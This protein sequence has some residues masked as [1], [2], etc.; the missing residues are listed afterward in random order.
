MC[1]H[2][3]APSYDRLQQ[4]FGVTPVEPAQVDIWPGYQGPFLRSESGEV[5]AC[6][7]VFGLLPGWAKDQ[8][9]ARRTYNARSETVSEKPSYRSAWRQAR[10][11]VIPAV[12]IYEPDWRTGKAVPARIARADGGLMLIAGLWDCWS[13]PDCEQ[14]FSYT[15]LT[16][17]ADD[18]PLM[19][20]YHRPEDEKR[21]VVILPS[22]S[23][24]AWLTAPAEKSRE[25]L[26]Q[27]PAARLTMA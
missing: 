26:L 20:Q 9:L 1:S 15:M 16:V 10:H 11:C 6:N 8:T 22:G 25:L 23:M 2:Y 7:G 27:Y 3:E 13:S 17:N 19:N 18:H 12:A 21:M 14:V 5:V 4:A 24:E